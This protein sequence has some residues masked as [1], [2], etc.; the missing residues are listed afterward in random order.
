MSNTQQKLCKK[1]FLPCET[2]NGLRLAW[3][4]KATVWLFK[5]KKEMAGLAAYSYKSMVKQDVFQYK[6]VENC[7]SH[8][9]YLQGICGGFHIKHMYKTLIHTTLLNTALEKLNCVGVKKYVKA[10]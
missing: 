1:H 3:K 4:P 8:T 9:S 6:H 7:M 5:K 2:R 10:N